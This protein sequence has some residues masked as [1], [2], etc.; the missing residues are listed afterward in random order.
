M[1][2]LNL[3]FLTY[4]L[5]KNPPDQSF[6]DYKSSEY[7][8]YLL[9]YQYNDLMIRYGKLHTSLGKGLTFNNSINLKDIGLDSNLL[10]SE[11]TV[12]STKLNMTVFYGEIYNSFYQS[13]DVQVSG[14][15]LSK[16]LVDNDRYSYTLGT[17]FVD[18]NF[19]EPIAQTTTNIFETIQPV[20][21]NDRHAFSV[22]HQ[23]YY[24]VGSLYYEYAT[25]SLSKESN[26]HYVSSDFYIE[27]STVIFQYSHYEQFNLS[28]DNNIFQL[29]P[30]A[31]KSYPY[32][33]PNKVLYSLNVDESYVL[34]RQTAYGVTYYTPIIEDSLLEISWSQENDRSETKYSDVYAQL[35]YMGFD[36]LEFKTGYGVQYLNIVPYNYIN[37]IEDIKGTFMRTIVSILF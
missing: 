27:D 11:L 29:A 6:I 31:L 4:Y 36:S 37:I 7:F 12:N 13:R 30:T 5:R 19:E 2:S 23:L 28:H 1:N 20:A 33:L 3:S 26:A 18:Y 21:S 22:Y 17:T 14:Y 35:D 8:N 15:E 32:T 9:S 25:T 34:N 16:R 10:G 24:D